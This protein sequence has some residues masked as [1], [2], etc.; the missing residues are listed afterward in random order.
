M[1]SLTHSSWPS[2]KHACASIREAAAQWQ[3]PGVE[4]AQDCGAW[5]QP[6]LLMLKVSPC[7]VIPCYMNHCVRVLI[8]PLFQKVVFHVIST[9]KQLRA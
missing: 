9:K 8:W 1:N 3:I 2:G 5:Q 7:A 4:R 6:C